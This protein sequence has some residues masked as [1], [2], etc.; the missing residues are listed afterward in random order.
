[1]LA[2]ASQIASIQNFG[3]CM[4]AI[5]FFFDLKFDFSKYALNLVGIH[6]ANFGISTKVE[7][8]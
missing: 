1:M 5:D 6:V 2:K 7:T 3:I 8:E 4:E